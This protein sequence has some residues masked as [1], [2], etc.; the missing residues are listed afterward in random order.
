MNPH[1]D[2]SRNALEQIFSSNDIHIDAVAFN[3]A[4]ADF[5]AE[6]VFKIVVGSSSV[7]SSV[8]IIGKSP[9][10]EEPRSIG[11]TIQTK[12]KGVTPEELMRVWRINQ[13]TAEQTLDCTTQLKKQDA[14]AGILEGFQP[15]TKY[16]DIKESS[17]ISSLIPSLQKMNTS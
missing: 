9:F 16:F 10:V 17:S 12:P 13:D 3:K 11:A 14:A 8:A 6:Q 15:M 7:N 2:N 1:I 5:E 4:V